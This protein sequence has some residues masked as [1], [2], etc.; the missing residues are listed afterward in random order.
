MSKHFRRSYFMPLMFV[1]FMLT[2]FGVSLFTAFASSGP[3]ILG[4]EMNTNGQVE[5]L[6]LG[7]D[8]DNLY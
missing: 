7:A 8:C 5:Y 6:C 4:S 2:V 3:L 1:V